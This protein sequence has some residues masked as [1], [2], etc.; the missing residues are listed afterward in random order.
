MQEYLLISSAT[1]EKTIELLERLE[2]PDPTNLFVYL[3]I[4]GNLKSEQLEINIS[5]NHVKYVQ[6][7][8]CFSKVAFSQYPSRIR[9]LHLLM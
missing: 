8:D 9:Q 6:V 5:V 4:L 7:D 1:I 2:S 3:D